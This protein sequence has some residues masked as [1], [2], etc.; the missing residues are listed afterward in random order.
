MPAI[1]IIY[2]T[3]LQGPKGQDGSGGQVYAYDWLP[4]DGYI[5]SVTHN[6]NTKQL[7]FMFLDNADGSYFDVGEIQCLSNN[8]VQF[9]VTELPSVAG[10]KIFIRQ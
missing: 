6:L 4:G 3:G 2:R 8:V 1:K 9:T 10:W 7:S 5:K